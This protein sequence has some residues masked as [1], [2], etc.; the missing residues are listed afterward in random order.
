MM[1]NNIRIAIVG[2]VSAGKSTVLNSLFVEQ[3][4]DM[5]IRR[6][7]MLP[8]VYTETNDDTNNIDTNQILNNNTDMNNQIINKQV[9]LSTNNCIEIPYNVPR[10]FDLI[11]LH[12]NTF[13]EIYDLPGLDDGETEQI[14]FDYLKKNFKKM[15]IVLFVINIEEALNTSGSRRILDE[16]ITNVK[17][18]HNLPKHLCVLVNKCDDMDENQDFEDEEFEEMFTQAKRVIDEKTNDIP[19]LKTTIVKYCAQDAYIYRTFKKNNKAELDMKNKAK[20]GVNEVGKNKWKKMTD[21]E[22]DSTVNNYLKKSDYQSRMKICGFSQLKRV[23]NELVLNDSAQGNYI[24]SHKLEPIKEYY[25]NQQQYEVDN[26]KLVEIID[27][28]NTFYQSISA[29]MNQFSIDKHQIVELITNGLYGFMDTYINQISTQTTPIEIERDYPMVNKIKYNLL[30]LEKRID[31]G[32]CIKE[33]RLFLDKYNEINDNQSH[34]LLNQIQD[35]ETLYQTEQYLHNFPQLKIYINYLLENKSKL[36]IPDIVWK[37]ILKYTPKLLFIGDNDSNPIIDLSEFLLEQFN[38]EYFQL[39]T[40]YYNQW[41]NKKLVDYEWFISFNTQI[42]KETL[43]NNK[44]NSGLFN[45]FGNSTDNYKLHIQSE[46]LL[47]EEGARNIALYI[48]KSNLSVV[49]PEYFKYYHECKKETQM[50]QHINNNR[51]YYCKLVFHLNMVYYHLIN[52]MSTSKM[53]KHKKEIINQ[54]RLNNSIDRFYSINMDC[55]LISPLIN[56]SGFNQILLNNIEQLRNNLQL[57]DF[58][59]NLVTNDL[60]YLD[61]LLKISIR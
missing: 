14:Y 10:V 8:Q 52:Y 32:I 25:D 55:N 26:L 30:E 49:F 34:Y 29:I 19:N 40:S 13:L 35:N 2:P 39:L 42:N 56:S 51:I 24:L 11:D 27:T 61:I 6:T 36:E 16:I 43:P 58:I 18:N 60:N 1:S 17:N 5:K 7:T 59:E 21:R 57:N 3:Y 15:D 46:M 22:K 50:V 54:M 28:S 23:I 4:S 41:L 45:I 44:S 47:T 37:N 12:K 48:D 9:E 53:S 20:F 38:T 31:N 33:N